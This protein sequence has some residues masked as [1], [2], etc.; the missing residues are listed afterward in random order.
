MMG[1]TQATDD[2]PTTITLTYTRFDLERGTDP[3]IAAYKLRNAET[4]PDDVDTDMLDVVYDE[5]VEIE[6]TDDDVDHFDTTEEL[7]QAIYTGLERDQV[8]QV[9]RTEYRSPMIGDVFAIDGTAYVVARFGFDELE[10][11][12]DVFTGEN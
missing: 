10:N 1:T 11:V 9:D 2:E 7:L 5:Q 4:T 12:D 6:L 8:P 3:E